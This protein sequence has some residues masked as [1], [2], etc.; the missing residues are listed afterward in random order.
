ML[1][2]FRVGVTHG[3]TVGVKFN[4]NWDVK[5]DQNPPGGE[6]LT[7]DGSTGQV[8]VGE[9]P[10]VLWWNAVRDFSIFA[11]VFNMVPRFAQV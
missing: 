7:I 10:I 1:F 6:F 5:Y 9:V 3:S 8:M 2:A 11:A 4:D